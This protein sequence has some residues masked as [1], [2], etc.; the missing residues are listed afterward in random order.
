MSALG[1]RRLYE[2][3]AARLET[4][5]PPGRVLWSVGSQTCRF[6]GTTLTIE[7]PTGS[8]AYVYA[9]DVDVEAV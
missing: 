9:P 5:E 1:D 3:L 7:M 6:D 8:L 4:P 2:D